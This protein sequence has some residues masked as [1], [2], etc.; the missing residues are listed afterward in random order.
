MFFGPSA[1]VLVPAGARSGASRDM[2]ALELFVLCFRRR[3]GPGSAEFETGSTGPLGRV[4]RAAAPH[5]R[6]LTK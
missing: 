2:P 4:G 3:F 6:K 1:V 5:T